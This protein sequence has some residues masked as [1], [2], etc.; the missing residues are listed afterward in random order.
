VVIDGGKGQLNAAWEAMRELGLAEHP[1]ISLAK[2]EEEVFVVGRA[3]SLRMSRRSPA[4]RMLQQARDEAHRFAVTFQ[5]HRRS[6]RTVTSELLTIPGVG[7]VTAAKLR[8]RHIHTVG[9]VARIGEA[10]LA[11]NPSELF[12]EIGLAIKHASP[13]P[14]TGIAG[15]TDGAI[16]YVPTAAAY[17]EGGYEVESACRVD[18]EAAEMIERVTVGLLEQLAG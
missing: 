14:W 3:E 18:P 16:G 17:P 1:L 2:R 13:F 15:Y 7:P 5:R 12:C 4:L 8:E 11:A 6:A 9:H 10:A